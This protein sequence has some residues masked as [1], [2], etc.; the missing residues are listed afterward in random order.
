MKNGELVEVRA[1]FD[2]FSG[3]TIVD[4][5]PFS[6]VFPL[7][8]EYASVHPWVYGEPID[9]RGEVCYNRYGI[10]RVLEA[11]QFRRIYAWRGV[12][13]F[14][15]A[16]DDERRPDSLWV[17]YEPGCTF[18]PYIWELIEVPCG[19]GERCGRDSPQSSWSRPR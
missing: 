11:R 5:R 9:H 1:T 3:D 19:G 12:P 2:R 15:E 16:G 7:T 10:P 4:G 14:I 17:P 13:V 18:L 8:G 6:N